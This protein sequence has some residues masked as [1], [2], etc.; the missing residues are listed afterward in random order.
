MY[1]NTK[2]HS[3]TFFDHVSLRIGI[4]GRIDG[5]SFSAHLPPVKVISYI[6]MISHRQSIYIYN[7][8]TVT[9]ARRWGGPRDRAAVELEH[10]TPRNAGSDHCAELS[11]RA[12]LTIRPPTPTCDLAW[13]WHS[14][15]LPN[16][17]P[18]AALS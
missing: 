18:K 6:D 15:K 4:L 9:P 13:P 2:T 10:T 8:V 17:L 14:T 5:P 11:V 7:P 3:L 12:S 1:H 16:A